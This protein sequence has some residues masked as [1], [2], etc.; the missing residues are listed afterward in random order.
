MWT[1]PLHFKILT[2]LAG[3]AK[4]ETV[5]RSLGLSVRTCRRHIAEILTRLN[6]TSRFQVVP[7]RCGSV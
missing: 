1:T 4:D 6:A 7:T 5:A 2:M 3:G